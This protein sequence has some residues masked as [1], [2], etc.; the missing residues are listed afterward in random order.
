[1][2]TEE[3][4]QSIK[5]YKYVS[6]DMFDTLVLRN[7]SRPR[8][9]FSIVDIKL[10]REGILVSDFPSKRI[11]AENEAI[12]CREK[13][14]EEISINDIYSRFINISDEDRT[15]VQEIEKETE[16]Q[17]CI[18]NPIFSAVLEYC[19]ENG[20]I[21]IIATDMYLD[22]A[23]ITTMLEKCGISYNYLYLSSERMCRKSRG[24]LFKCILQELG[25][26]N[27]DIVH[28]GDNKKSDYLVP[29]MIGI[30]SVLYKGIYYPQKSSIVESVINALSVN[31]TLSEKN[32]Y[33]KEGYTSFG[34]LIWGFC[35]WL[36]K[37]V[38]K[39]RYDQIIFLS[40]DGYIIQRAYSQLY[41]ED[42]SIYAYFSRRSLT[43]PQLIKA[44]SFKEIVDIVAYIKREE[45]IN[46]LLHKLGIEDEEFEQK[47]SIDFGSAIYREKLINNEYDGLYDLII[48]RV[49]DNA[50]VEASLLKRYMSQIFAGSRVAIVDIG[51]YGTMQYNLEK[52]IVS[53]GIDCSIDGYYLGYLGNR[54]L[55]INAKG[56]I[57]NSDGPSVTDKELLFGYNGLIET[58]FTA[59]HGS[60]K[61]YKA[62]GD[63]VEPVFEEWEKENWPSVSNIHDGAIAFL[64]KMKE[65]DFSDVEISS[66]ISW[67]KFGD[68][69]LNPNT[70][71]LNNFGQLLFFDTYVEPLNK[72]QGMKKYFIN[73]KSMKNDLLQSNW[74][75]G[76]LKSMFKG[77]V[78]PEKLYKLLNRIKG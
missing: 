73:P 13:N 67:R 55:N 49:K 28:I 39:N 63:S 57:F 10:R 32:V 56:Y 58:F 33:W 47:L 48:K 50:S 25:I 22:K 14:T 17:Y 19:K 38:E 29:K 34:P 69:L 6:F 68:L 76:F 2:K 77:I 65:L 61:N 42:N 23:T 44:S 7:V 40:R 62:S 27:S 5:G 31:N 3:I 12:D 37:E 30:K 20:V 16:I 64:E 72:Y 1:M 53:M 36:H 35:Q 11:Q 75:L 74:K 4:I 24:S 52:A 51:W 26:K 60:V 9:I 70:S 21:V 46:T 15:R 78:K 18:A 8:D 54:Y 66:E 41:A 43:V 45:T 59:N 71:Q